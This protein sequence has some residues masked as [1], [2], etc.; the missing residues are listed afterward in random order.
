[1]QP[2]IGVDGLAPG[3]EQ[4]EAPLIE[5]VPH[6]FETSEEVGE[7]E[8]PV[9]R[10][11]TERRSSERRQTPPPPPAPAPPRPTPP[12]PPRREP[13]SHIAMPARDKAPGGE[14]GAPKPPPAPPRAPLS[15]A[16]QRI[17]EVPGRKPAP[18]PGQEPAKRARPEAPPAQEP[19]RAARLEAPTTK[20][21]AGAESKG[22]PRTRPEPAR[23]A[24]AKA[25]EPPSAPPKP[26]PAP[27]AAKPAAPLDENERRRIQRLLELLEERFVQ[28]QVSETTYADLKARYTA[29]L[30]G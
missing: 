19:T 16:T 28:G 26:S 20:M 7:E 4:E 3:V 9:E 5:A 18:P 22:T 6:S 13:I 10:R 27:A 8:A 14:N 1:M 30:G 2:M 23:K 29:R 17:I 11:K 24:P 15:P 12:P 25:P 21:G